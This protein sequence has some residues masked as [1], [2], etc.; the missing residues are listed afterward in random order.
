MRATNGQNRFLCFRS[1][2]AEQF[3]FLFPGQ[4]Q[5][6]QGAD[7]RYLAFGTGRGQVD[8]EP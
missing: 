6:R 5:V 8:R 7:I 1:G 2:A 4:R 3:R